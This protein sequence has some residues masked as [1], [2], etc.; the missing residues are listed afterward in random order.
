[1][2]KLAL[3]EEE[4]QFEIAR[5]EMRPG[6]TLVARPTRPLASEA[7]S[8]LHAYLSRALPETRVVVVDA[9]V[10]LSVVSKTMA[11]RSPRAVASIEASDTAVPMAGGANPAPA[12]SAATDGQEDQNG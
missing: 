5:L 8:R 4:L 6:D 10:E 12:E 9:A 2:T 3:P 11:K 1:M 7:V